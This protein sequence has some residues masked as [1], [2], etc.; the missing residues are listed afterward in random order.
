ML[1]SPKK[2]ADAVD[3]LDSGLPPLYHRPQS[4]RISGRYRLHSYSPL[5]HASPLLHL[6]LP[7][8]RRHR[9]RQ[10]ALEGPC[11]SPIHTGSD[12]VPHAPLAFGYRQAATSATS[13]ATENG[14]GPPTPSRSSASFLFSVRH[15]FQE[16]FPQSPHRR[17]RRGPPGMGSSSLRLKLDGEAQ[18]AQSNR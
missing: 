5:R 10:P 2:F 7:S 9:V 13:N 12:V 11:L 14:P 18:S 8:C 1:S 16:H 3:A 15:G 17:L 4:G 6:W